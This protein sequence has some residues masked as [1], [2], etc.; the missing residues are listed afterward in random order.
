MLLHLSGY[1][2]QAIC[3]EDKREVHES[4]EQYH[5][6]KVPLTAPIALL[7]HH[8]N[9]HPD[10]YVQQQVYLQSHPQDPSLCDAT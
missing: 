3:A 8:F 7:Q 4:I 1:L 2:R 10:P 5:Q 6:G 9:L